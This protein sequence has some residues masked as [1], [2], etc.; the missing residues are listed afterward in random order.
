MAAIVAG[1]L[2]PGALLARYEGGG[3]TDCYTTT[4]P[5]KVSQAQYVEA[6]Y[7][8]PLFRLERLILA[9]LVSRPSRDADAARLARGDSETFAAWTVEARTDDQLLLCDYQGLT[10]SWLMIREELVCGEQGARLFFGSAVVPGKGDQVSS[11]VFKALL[12]FHQLY[13]RLLLASAVR[14][15]RHRRHRLSTGRANA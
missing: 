6:F 2:P 5:G 11:S 8:T 12:G 3:H 4:T 10:R 15:L 13:S 9:L 14:R 1:I 7:T